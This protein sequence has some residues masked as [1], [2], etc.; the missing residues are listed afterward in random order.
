MLHLQAGIHFQEVEVAGRVDDELDRA[1]GLV[2]DRAGERHCLR[3]HRVAGVFVEQRAR[4]LLDHLLMAPLNRAFALA[5]M[6]AI[7]LPVGQ[8]LDL[9]MARLFDILLQKHPVVAEG[10]AGFAGGGAKALAELR[11]ARDEPHAL[12]AAAGGGLD[13]HRIADMPGDFG[14]LV[15][16]GD[17]L[18]VAGDGVDPGGASQFLRFDLVAHRP[19]RV[20]PW[21][22]EGHSGG[23]ERFWELGILRQEAVSRMHRFSAGLGAGGDDPFDQQIALG[24]RRRPDRHRLVGDADVRRA[25]VRL[26]MDGDGLDPHRLGGADHPAGDF[27]AVGDENLVEHGRKLSRAPRAQQYRGKRRR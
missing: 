4:R 22:D 16:I 20:R 12:A 27:T 26:G 14:R 8:H 7:A 24:D 5:E 17:H 2:A 23:G 13:H 15:R 25:G 6:D 11:F 18:E 3:A 9:D 10:G 19:N 1:G 21:A